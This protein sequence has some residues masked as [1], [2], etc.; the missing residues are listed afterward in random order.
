MPPKLSGL[1]DSFDNLD[2]ISADSLIPYLKNA[3]TS[4]QLENYLANRILYPTTLPLT[5][6]DMKI[7]LAILRE[8]LR[9]NGPKQSQVGNSLLGDNPFLNITL[10]KIIIPVRFLY[11]VGNLVSLTWAFVD[12]L[13]LNRR[14][15][16]F[17]DLWTVD[18]AGDFDEI[19]GSILLPQF[20]GLGDRMIISLQGRDY[21]IQAGSLTYVACPK[22]KCQISYKFDKGKILGKKSNTVEVYGGRMGLMI[23]GRIL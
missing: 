21:T 8:A 4:V 10:S 1:F 15:Q 9:I 3:P 12:G 20:A 18:L 11:Y 6:L 23:D 16:E 7:D 5:D 13:L 22:Q 17:G 14:K 2:A 19:V